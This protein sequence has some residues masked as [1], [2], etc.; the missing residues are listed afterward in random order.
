MANLDSSSQLGNKGNEGGSEV[1]PA[2]GGTLISPNQFSDKGGEGSGAD[3]AGGGKIVSPN[4]STASKEA[5]GHMDGRSSKG[6]DGKSAKGK[7]WL[8]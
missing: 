1:K 6:N 4:Y 8:S 2:S 5:N 7:A 3:Q